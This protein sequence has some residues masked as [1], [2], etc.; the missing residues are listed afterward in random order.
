MPGSGCRNCGAGRTGRWVVLSDDAGVEGFDPPPD[1]LVSL[2]AGS[3]VPA[4]VQPD[5]TT[6]TAAA[7]SS[8]GRSRLDHVIRS[9]LPSRVANRPVSKSRPEF[10]SIRQEPCPAQHPQSPRSGWLSPGPGAGPA[11]LGPHPGN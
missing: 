11:H 3:V 2:A 7:T 8:T 9:D 6:R 4:P 1:A 10:L 5:T